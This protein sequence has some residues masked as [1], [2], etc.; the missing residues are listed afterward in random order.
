[1]A[2]M[3][4]ALLA[5][6]V[7]SAE[8]SETPFCSKLIF[9]ETPE[10]GKKWHGGIRMT[11][12]LI[13][14]FYWNVNGWLTLDLLAAG[15]PNLFKGQG[16]TLT[17][18]LKVFTIKSRPFSFQLKERPYRI[19]GGI[20]IYRA[21]SKFGDST[22]TFMDTEDKSSVF[23]VT[24]SCQWNKHG[25]NLFTS[26]SSSE[27]QNKATYFIVPGYHYPISESWSFSL[28]Y[29]M[30]N[31]RFIPLKILQ[32]YYD[33]D[34]LEFDNRERDMY[35]FMF[36]G[37]QYKRTHLRVDLNLAS[38]YTFQNLVIPMLGIGWNF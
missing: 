32:F 30:T 1:M 22:A 16:G 20:K 25:V 12:V 38:H 11:D 21:N 33:A 2:T 37:C 24:Q 36:F 17:D 13:W 7:R 15:L 26:L 35:S 4:V 14:D 10:I 5:G 31:T 3:A 34:E 28:E 23:F 27:N 18:N 6:L 8:F 19:A 9:S 29:Y